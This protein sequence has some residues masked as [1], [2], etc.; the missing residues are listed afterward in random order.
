[1]HH[2]EEGLGAQERAGRVHRQDAVPVGEGGPMQGR[3]VADSGVVHENVHMAEM[4]L[5]GAGE[6]L[7]AGRVGDVARYRPGPPRTGGTQVGR[8]LLNRLPRAGS[9]HDRG[10]GVDERSCHRH[11]DAAAR[12]GDHRAPSSERQGPSS[13]STASSRIAPRASMVRAPSAAPAAAG[14]PKYARGPPAASKLVCP[15]RI[16]TLSE[17]G[18]AGSDRRIASRTSSGR[19]AITI[20]LSYCPAWHAPLWNSSVS[21]GAQGLRV[22][23]GNTIRAPASGRL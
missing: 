23:S 5:G 13:A 7:H 3:G 4:D 6:R 20:E 11:A 19:A 10:A 15:D 21:R 2:G 18:L 12:A 14:A 8:D 9:H 22:T 1:G 17:R 16:A